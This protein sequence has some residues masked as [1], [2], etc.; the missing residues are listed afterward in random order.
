MEK[1]STKQR[2]CFFFQC[3]YAAREVNCSCVSGEREEGREENLYGVVCAQ[4]SLAK[5]NERKMS[6]ESEWV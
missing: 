3:I 5:N 4:L 6:E 2:F 1:H